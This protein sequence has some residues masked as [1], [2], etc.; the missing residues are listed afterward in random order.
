[1]AAN[2]VLG[3]AIIGPAIPAALALAAF[4]RAGAG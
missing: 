1:M 4:I 2:H 3:Y